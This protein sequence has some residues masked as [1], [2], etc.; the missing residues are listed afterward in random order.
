MHAWVLT[1]VPPLHDGLLTGVHAW[2]L[3]KG[4]RQKQVAKEG[5]VSK[6]IISRSQA[7]F[8]FLYML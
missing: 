7:T 4:P 8:S 2:V 5:I 6:Y 3:W 1:D